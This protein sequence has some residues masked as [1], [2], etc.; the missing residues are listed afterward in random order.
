[1]NLTM[2][3]QGKGPSNPYSCQ[4]LLHNGLPLGDYF[5]KELKKHE[6]VSDGTIAM[7]VLFA[8]PLP[9]AVHGS[10]FH[11]LAARFQATRISQNKRGR[12][13][14]T[15]DGFFDWQVNTA[16]IPQSASISVHGFHP[17]M[18]DWEDYHNE[19]PPLGPHQIFCERFF[20]CIDEERTVPNLE[21]LIRSITVDFS[22]L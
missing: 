22:P 18:A 15:G 10:D 2:E 19:L 14:V 20:G 9:I 6:R 13:P 3:F 8:K 11:I 1:M 21:H 5:R 17:D 4:D 16:I 7:H 12:L